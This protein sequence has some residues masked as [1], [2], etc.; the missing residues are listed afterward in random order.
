MSKIKMQNKNNKDM[1]ILD[2]TTIEVKYEAEKK[3]RIEAEEKLNKRLLELSIVAEE[4]DLLD[5]KLDELE[6]RQPFVA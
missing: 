3:L 4:R 2:E 5:H 1:R 6:E